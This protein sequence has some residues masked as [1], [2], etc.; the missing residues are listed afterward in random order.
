MLLNPAVLS[1][2]AQEILL[3]EVSPVFTEADN[4]KF[5][6]MPTKVEV[7][8]TLAASNQHA[9]P[10]TDGL[11]SFFYKQ[12]FKTMGSPLTEVA[13][14]VFSGEKPTL[15]QRTSKM[16][17]GSKPKKE[18]SLKPKDKR[19][20]SLLNS[21]FKTI[22]GLKSRR[23]KCTATRTLSP[24]QLVAG[25]D[26]QIYHGIN[27][28]RDAIQ[29]V[30][31]LTKSGCGIADTDYEAAF[32]FLVM[33]WVFMVLSKKGLSE[34]VIERIKN[35]YRDNISIVVVN[36]IEG[37]S[38]KNLRLSLRQGDIPSM[39]FFAYGIDPLITY[40]ERRLTGILITSIPVQGPV[41]EHTAKLAPVE[42]RYRV[43][44]YAD[45]LKPAVTTMEE[46]KLVNDASALFE[47]ASGCRL[48]RDPASQ[49]C[50]FLPLGKWRRQLQ[51][52]DLPTVC[53]YFVLS[54]YLDTVG[55]QLRATWTQTR[56]A[57]VDILQNRVSN[58]INPWCGG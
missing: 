6:K 42:E 21:D 2:D 13:K 27:L 29:A 26:R 22:S 11:T 10:G 38:V 44:S 4:Q 31:K 20:I 50:K 46:F 47:A 45:D 30:S 55:F 24:Y 40:L 19:R 58:V 36:N 25:E 57:N 53:Q 32:D 54:E 8:D 18:S 15:S 49:K 35:L 9:A 16:V 3:A 1:Q 41:L 52:E 56:K 17:F 48:H 28:A 7:F 23:F 51:H 39:F 37:K 33:D 14:A 34:V 43:I 5:L 12:C